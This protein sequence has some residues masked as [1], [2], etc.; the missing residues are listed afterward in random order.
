M[1]PGV[2]GLRAETAG[3][4]GSDEKRQAVRERRTTPEVGAE[5]RV[6]GQSAGGRQQRRVLYEKDLGFGRVFFCNFFFCSP[7]NV[8]HGGD[9]FLLSFLTLCKLIRMY[10]RIHII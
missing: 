10:T 4:A 5:Q 8:R 9:F 3:H 2:F 7:P 6:R 1:R